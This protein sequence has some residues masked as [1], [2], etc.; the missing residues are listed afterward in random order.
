MIEMLRTADGS[1][2]MRRLLGGMFQA[3]VDAEATG[4]G[5]RTGDP[6]RRAEERRCMHPSGQRA[7]HVRT[8]QRH[9]LLPYDK[10]AVAVGGLDGHGA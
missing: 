3:V 6:H 5:Q 1:E 7:G 10:G 8:C 2:L 9:R 4:H